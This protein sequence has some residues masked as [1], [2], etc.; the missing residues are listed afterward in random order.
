MAREFGQASLEIGRHHSEEETFDAY[1]EL[2][3]EYAQKASGGS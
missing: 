1:E 2:Y 3:R